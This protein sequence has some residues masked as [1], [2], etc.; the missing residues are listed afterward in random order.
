MWASSGGELAEKIKKL[1][2][3]LERMKTTGQEFGNYNAQLKD[4]INRLDGYQ[5][6]LRQSRESLLQAAPSRPS[7]KKQ[8]KSNRSKKK[9]ERSKA[10]AEQSRSTFLRICQEVDGVVWSMVEMYCSTPPEQTP[11]HKF[12]CLSSS[13]LMKKRLFA[14]PRLEILNLLRD[15]EAQKQ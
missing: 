1:E 15:E 13:D 4:I 2:E 3:V 10:F 7:E 8:H 12:F 11:D 14:A 5:E 6:E 9:E